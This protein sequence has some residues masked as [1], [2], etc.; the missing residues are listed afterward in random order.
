MSVQLATKAACNGTVC[1]T[2]FF[3]QQKV[4]FVLRYATKNTVYSCNVEQ[5]ATVQF[6]LATKNSL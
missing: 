2:V 5:L 4:Q 6:V 1:S 3:L